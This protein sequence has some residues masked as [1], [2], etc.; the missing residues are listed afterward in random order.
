MREL[1]ECVPLANLM[2]TTIPAHLFPLICA[3]R[4]IRKGACMRS[5][6]ISEAA[7]F[8]VLFARLASASHNFQR[9]FC[10]LLMFLANMSSRRPLAFTL[11][12][13][14]LCAIMFRFCGYTEL[15]QGRW[16]GYV[17]EAST[18]GATAPATIK[19]HYP[20]SS[21]R[22]VASPAVARPSIPSTAH[23]PSFAALDHLLVVARQ[24]SE[25][26]SWI[27]AKLPDVKT[28]I[29]VV[30]DPNAE[31]PVP[32]NKGHEAMVYLTYIMNLRCHQQPGC[33]DNL[34]LDTKKEDG[35]KP[36]VLVF[37][38]VWS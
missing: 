18:P 35:Y 29:Y 33:S 3:R 5:Y 16:R 38:R 37:R 1:W 13:F 21:V 14:A 34:H 20:V 9:P 10:F 6:E 24:L 11:L 23:S 22:E 7:V 4:V 2:S 30:D 36:E 32:A 31:L 12:F 17:K 19:I 25:D 8:S 28:A 26:V 15:R 27:Q